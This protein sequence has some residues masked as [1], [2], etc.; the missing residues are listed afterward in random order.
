SHQFGPHRNLSSGTG[1]KRSGI[2]G[3]S[4]LAEL[5]LDE[6]SPRTAKRKH[7]GSDRRPR[8][9][10]NTL[11]V[12][13]LLVLPWNWVEPRYWALKA[14]LPRPKNA[15]VNVAWATPLTTCTVALPRT[16]P[17]TSRLTVPSGGTAPEAGLIETVKVTVGRRGLTC[18][19]SVVVVPMRVLGGVAKI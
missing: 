15:T 8:K 5:R 9:A 18:A 19:C 6:T 2:S 4:A 11:M 13:A 16:L 1:W 14:K 7:A 12:T 17:L 3:R 10:Q